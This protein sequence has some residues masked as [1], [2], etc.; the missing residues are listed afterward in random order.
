[1]L[2]STSINA[3]GSKDVWFIEFGAL[4]HMTSHQEWF[5]KL[6]VP[7][8]PSYVETREDI[9]HTIRHIGNQT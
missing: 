2:G 3:S 6:Q 5:R 8:Q 1:M 4:N 7:N 9:T